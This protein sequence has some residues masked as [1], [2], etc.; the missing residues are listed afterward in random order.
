MPLTSTIS[1]WGGS[2]DKKRRKLNFGEVLRPRPLIRYPL[3]KPH[4]EEQHQ[5]PKT[6][7]VTKTITFLYDIKGSEKMIKLL[8]IARLISLLDIADAINALDEEEEEYEY[9][10]KEESLL[11]PLSAT[12]HESIIQRKKEDIARFEEKEQLC[13][14]L[15]RD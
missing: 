10:D 5:P 14:R 1:A 13:K 4:E 11:F 7:V 12:E 9:Q 15:H 8:K 2:S 3:S 6:I